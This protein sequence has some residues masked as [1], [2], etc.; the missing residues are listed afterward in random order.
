M[1]LTSCLKLSVVRRGGDR[2]DRSQRCAC[3]DRSAEQDKLTGIALAADR[4]GCEDI[5]SPRAG[6]VINEATYDERVVRS[7]GYNVL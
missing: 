4:W 6:V 1:S 3:R 5:A 7:L 2:Q